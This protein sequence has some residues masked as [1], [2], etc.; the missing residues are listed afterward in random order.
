MS[1]M[2][3]WVMTVETFLQAWKLYSK[4]SLDFN[5]FFCTRVAQQLEDAV[6]P[7]ER[8][9]MKMIWRPWDDWVDYQNIHFDRLQVI[10]S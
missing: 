9:F 2:L 5:V 8:P 4:E 1:A 6:V 10:H 7:R 3:L